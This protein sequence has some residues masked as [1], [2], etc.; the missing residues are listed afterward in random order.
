VPNVTAKSF[1][2]HL[3]K[4]VSATTKVAWFVLN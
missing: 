1:T 3:S 2:V 4:A